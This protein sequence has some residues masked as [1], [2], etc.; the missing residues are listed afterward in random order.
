MEHDSG[1]LGPQHEPSANAD[2]SQLSEV[3]GSLHGFL[4][5]PGCSRF[6]FGPCSEAHLFEVVKL[7]EV[8]PGN[9][10]RHYSDLA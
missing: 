4:R 5:F 2:S 6:K 9:E 1:Y 7:D 10:I 3:P 8:I